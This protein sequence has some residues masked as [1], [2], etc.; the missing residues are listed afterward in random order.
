V[1]RED[2]TAGPFLERWLANMEST[3]TQVEDRVVN[4][5]ALFDPRIVPAES[6]AWLAGWF[7]V[8][9][10]PAWDERRQ[11]LFIKRAMD[12][13]RWRGT[14][15]GLRLALELAFNRCIDES[16]FDEPSAAG[17]GPRQI[18]IVETYQ[19]RL[20]GSLAA[21]D[22]SGSES[23]PREVRRSVLWTPA[24]GNAGLVDRWASVLGREP[25]VAEEIAP[26]SL[27]P[28]GGDVAT[29]WA[30]FCQSVLG[31]VPSIGAAE[32][33]RWRNFLLASHSAVSTAVLPRDFPSSAQDAADWRAFSEGTGGSLVR[34]RW[35]DFLARRYRRIERLNGAWETTWPAFD[36][37]A[38]P[39]VLPQTSAAQ[40]D[41]LQFERQVLAM[42]RTAHRFSVL[43]PVADVTSDPYELDRRLGLARRIVDLEKPGHTVFDVR[44]YWAFFRIGE[45]RLGIDTQLG[46]GSRAPELIP[47]AVLGRAY[48]GASFVGGAARP[49][50]ADRVLVVH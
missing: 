18:R 38:L 10:D 16:M 11:R 34:E 42:H 40:T 28:P 30:A 21:G 3:L 25:T 1:Y 4:L 45:A 12:F 2:P 15:H 23:G 22:P 6:L 41:W 27:V 14:V 31:C 9:C 20:A 47:T 49:T 39:D 48:I 36:L 19:T 29:T 8:A 46:A 17:D 33:T 37:V 32:R 7:D 13:F 5:Q 43:L 24:E 44:F 35:Q 50:D 26:F